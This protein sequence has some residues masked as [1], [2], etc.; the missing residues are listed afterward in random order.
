MKFQKISFIMMKA[1]HS[2]I[3]MLGRNHIRRY[4]KLMLTNI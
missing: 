4:T 1:K 3:V 2:K